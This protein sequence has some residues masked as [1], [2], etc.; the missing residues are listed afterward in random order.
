L[1]LGEDE[2]VSIDTLTREQASQVIDA[3]K[4][5]PTKAGKAPQPPQSSPKPKGG[6]NWTAFWSK[7][8][9]EL[10]LSED[11]VHGL[12]SAYCAREIKSLTEFVTCQEDL[13]KFLAYLEEL[14]R[15][16]QGEAN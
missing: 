15:E 13:D 14:H 8:K 7:A 6:I 16:G 12:A 9:G 4:G 2:E 11:E 10:G 3:L 5:Q 1:N